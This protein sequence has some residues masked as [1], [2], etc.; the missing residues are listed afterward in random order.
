MKALEMGFFAI[1]VNDMNLGKKFYSS[2][3]GWE[4]NERDAAFSYIMAG[5]NM[6]GALELSSE[7][8]K[9]SN[10]GP[11]MYFRAESMAKTLERVKQAEGR[12]IEKVAVDGGERGFTAKINDPFKNTIGFWAAED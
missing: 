7:N 4:F 12:L 10:S 2:V 8:F 5:E 3:M 6:I 11:L 9:P 1:P